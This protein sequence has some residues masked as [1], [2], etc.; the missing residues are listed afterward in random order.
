M[1][2][3]NRR[4]TRPTLT[5]EETTDRNRPLRYGINRLV[6]TLQGDL[7]QHAALEGFRVADRGNRHI[8]PSA[9]F[10]EGRNLR[11]DH[12]RSDIAG[13]D[14]IHRDIDAV[15]F[16]RIC[17]GLQSRIDFA[18]TSSGQ[19]HN[20]TIAVQLVVT[21]AFDIDEVFDAG[22]AAIIESNRR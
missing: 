22:T 12:D 5:S 13:L 20:E 7:Q 2:F 16:Q 9:G 21:G 14:V 6:G 8:D 18:I 4:T 11:C 10:H 3:L 17:D 19:T 1:V 15:I